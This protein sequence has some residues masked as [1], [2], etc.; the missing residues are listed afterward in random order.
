MI[1]RNSEHYADPTAGKAIENVMREN[2]RLSA[3]NRTRTADGVPS[4]APHATSPGPLR[5]EDS[6]STIGPLQLRMK[7]LYNKEKWEDLANA[8]ILQ[9]AEDYRVK[10]DELRRI[11]RRQ[12]SRREEIEKEILE[13]EAFFLSEWFCLLTNADG[14]VILDRLR[15]EV[16]DDSEEIPAA[17]VSA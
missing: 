14:A 12:K 3:R 1:F 5:T 4:R 13:I 8:A 11:P 17:G 16:P 10:R 7:D 6:L 2:R 15:K 9:Q